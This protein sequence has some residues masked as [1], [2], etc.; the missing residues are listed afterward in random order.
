MRQWRLGFG[1]PHFATLFWGDP[2]REATFC[3]TCS[4]KLLFLGDL[5]LEEAIMKRK[6]ALFW[7]PRLL[8]IPG[9][10][11]C[12]HPDALRAHKAQR[13]DLVDC[14]DHGLGFRIMVYQDPHIIRLL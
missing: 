14:Y 4:L 7:S 2:F 1:A 10:L 6:F 13:Q 12:R 5:F 3:G 11:E 8:Q 9:E